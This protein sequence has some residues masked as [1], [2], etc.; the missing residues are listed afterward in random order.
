VDYFSFSP[1]SNIVSQSSKFCMGVLKRFESRFGVQSLLSHGSLVICRFSDQGVSTASPQ[2]QDPD[3]ALTVPCVLLI[4][5]L[6]VVPS[7]S[8]L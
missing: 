7:P 4:C 6:P 8:L 1:S 2:L 3:V 5:L